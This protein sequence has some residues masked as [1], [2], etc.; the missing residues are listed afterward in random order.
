MERTGH[1]RVD[2]VGHGLGGLIGRYY[3]QRLGGDARVRTLITL[4]TPHSG[5][6]VVRA[7]PLHS[8]V[9]QTRPGS[10]VLRELAELVPGGC[11]TRFGCFWSAFDALVIPPETARLDHC[12]LRVSPIYVHGVGHVTLPVDCGVSARIRAELGTGTADRTG[13]RG[14]AGSVA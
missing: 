10:S 14:V 12:D 4:G 6:R 1:A 2:L 3:V 13:K 11:A 7:L 9:R 8:V 5:T